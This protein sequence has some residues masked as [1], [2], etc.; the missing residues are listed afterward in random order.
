[1]AVLVAM[2]AIVLLAPGILTAQSREVAGMWT[3]PRTSCQRPNG[4]L[5]S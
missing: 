2:G 3:T 1:M 4:S 5:K